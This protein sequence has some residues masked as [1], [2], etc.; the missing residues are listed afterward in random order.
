MT[1]GRRLAIGAP[2]ASLPPRR[3]KRRKNRGGDIMPMR[4][5]RSLF[6]VAAATPAVRLS[7]ATP[8]RPSRPSP[9]APEARSSCRKQPHGM[10]GRYGRTS[11]GPGASRARLSRKSGIGMVVRFTT[12][13]QGPPNQ[14]PPPGPPRPPPSHCFSAH[15]CA[16]LWGGGVRTCAVWGGAFLLHLSQCPRT[17]SRSGWASRRAPLAGRSCKSAQNPVSAGGR[18]K[19]PVRL[20]SR[21][22]PGS[23]RCGE[24]KM[25]PC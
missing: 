2:R 7:G 14:K 4:I 3:K 5:R 15:H 13:A 16:A 12:A 6:F 11:F 17:V 24:Q 23:F 18:T 22:P 8:A 9:A 21:R 20:G 1:T 25:N 19:C 10:R